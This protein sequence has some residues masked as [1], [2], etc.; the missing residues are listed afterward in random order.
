M[1]FDA[2]VRGAAL[3]LLAAVPVAAG[4]ASGRTLTA[5]RTSAEI[6]VDG[7]LD[8]A[9]WSDA[10]PVGDFVQEAPSF[11]HPT[12]LATEVRVLYD[13]QNLYVGARMRSGSAPAR[14]L[15]LVHR[16][17]QDSFS[18]WFGVAIDSLMDRRTALQYMVNAAGVQRDSLIHSD[19]VFDDSWDGIWDS[20]VH[21]DGEAWTVE[22]KI[23]FS[24]LRLDRSAD[25]QSW[26]INFVRINQRPWELSR[27]HVVPRDEAAFVSGF[28]QLT[29]LQGLKPRRR[30]ELAPYIS[31]QEKM[32]TAETYDD[33][34]SS[35]RLGLDAQLGLTP[36]SHLSLTVQPDFGQTEVDE[37]VLNL[38]TLETFFP[39]KRPFF[40]EGTDIFQLPG[41][42]LFYSRRIGRALGAPRLNGGET[43]VERPLAA[44]ILGAA[45]FTG[46]Y[47]NGLNVGG[48]FAL[49]GAADAVIRA[50]NGTVSDRPVAP[51][52]GSGVFRV[53]RR[54]GR[55]GNYVGAFASYAEQAGVTGRQAFTGALDGV[56]KTAD[57]TAN[58]RFV[59]AN[60]S[61][62]TRG[63]LAHDAFGRVQAAKS[64]GGGAYVGL[65]LIHAGRRF[66]PND[67][68]FL[69]RADRQQAR[70][71]VGKTWDRTWKSLRNWSAYFSVTGDR[72]LAGHR[73]YNRNVDGRVSTQ[74]T[75]DFSAYVGGGLTLPV[76][77][78]RELRTFGSPV[79]KYL[80]RDAQ[81]YLTAGMQTPGSRR[82]YLRLDL[83]RDWE[84]GGPSDHA[85][86]FQIVRP[87]SRFDLRFETRVNRIDGS[88]RWLE[89]QNGVPIVGLRRLDEVG[90][91]VRAS[92][93]FTP[94]LTTQVFTQAL[95]SSWNYRDLEEYVDERTR[96]PGATANR[97]AF[98]QRSLN[99]HMVTRWEVR[100]GSV[101][102]CVYTRGARTSALIDDQARVRIFDDLGPLLSARSDDVLQVKLSWLF[103]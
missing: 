1:S 91:L 30:R 29:G 3:S 80:R 4:E 33:R 14:V 45:K 22:L 2:V 96:R 24:M 16:R 50:G 75:S 84:T 19:N 53:T 76:D 68:G 20:A 97:T 79:K 85:T 92:Y 89:T 59:V 10:P 25:D 100:P 40:L 18:D 27:W 99:V 58:V 13:E 36:S 28:P 63:A 93:A 26:G 71:E 98:S 41:L 74:F 52:T 56:L 7:R 86:L 90:Q 83:E 44:D 81:P 11:G 55:S 8:E 46:K 21:R 37:V 64:W 77:D 95:L 39:E 12:A 47:G 88:L 60:S 32:R 101:L 87:S 94:R 62:G 65:N 51:R 15:P 34:G 9:G 67:L 42:Q 31:A 103:R 23:P 78:D 72:D 48:L 43:L 66:D 5:V 61:A 73:L 6:D 102:Y 49:T 54:A 82:W 38:S 57:R 70:V 17:D 35:A 69:A